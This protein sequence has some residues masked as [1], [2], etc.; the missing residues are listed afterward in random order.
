MSHALIGSRA[1]IW[2]I[3]IAMAPWVVA[4][5]RP[6]ILFIMSDDHTSQAVGAYGSR[7]AYL[8][9]TPNL[10]RLAE[11]G[12]LF[13]NAF[14]TNSICTP[15]RA[16]VMTGQYNHTNG[17]FDLNGR[18]EPENQHLAKEMKKA[19]YQTAMIG[20]W[21]LKAEPAAFD[22]YCVLPGQGKYFDP[23]FRI[24]GDKP[25]P[26]NTI[27]KEGMHSTDAITDITLNWFDE[28]REDDKPFFLMH[29]YKAPH[30]FF[31]YAPR[32]EEYLAEIAIP[33]PKNLWSQPQFG[34]LATRGAK[35]EMMPFIGTSIGR[36]NPRRNYAKHYEVDSWLSD[37]EAKR[38][39][40]NIYMKHY[41]RCVKGVDDNL[42]RL[43]AKLEETG[44]MDNT[45]I[46]YTGDQ[47][48]MLGEH[49]YMDKRWMYDESQ[50][51]PFLV[52]YPKS[53]PAGSRSDAIVENVDYGPTMLAFAGVETPEYMQGK[54]FREI[55]ETG[56]EPEG[57]KQ[58]TYY[59]YWMHMAHHDNPGH[60]G[61]RTKTHKLIYY[62]GVNYEGKQ[63][64]PPG[65]ELYDLVNDP[66][67][68]VNQIDNPE[69]AEVAKEMKQRLADLRK[70]VGDDGS[71]YPAV[72]DVVQEFWDYS[73]EDR[74]K[75][76]EISH[77]YVQAKQS[78]K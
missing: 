32:Y 47:G 17:V 14:C 10:D 7:L 6:N 46:I 8:D 16:C 25:W 71:H 38:E 24:Q 78:E 30:D 34:S 75:A 28:V 65:W 33:E 12:M 62:Y 68:V 60:L 26:K 73:D 54:S 67:E 50:R 18:I 66:T 56:Q 74:Q 72:E 39:A 77:E 43:F 41:L 51:M 59:R 3:A 13:E 21:H 45:V 35:D 4:D 23:E 57:W 22:Y 1:L 9:P 29:H 76:I 61:I 37:E 55:C 44:Q 64:T 11:E 63:Q 40:Y 52:R 53:I 70:R 15:S 20:K 69:Y 19:G 2:M 58:E 48:F 31:E 42:A 5:D 49:D 36:R 27:K